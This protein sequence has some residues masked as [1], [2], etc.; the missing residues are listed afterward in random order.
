MGP[1][2][3]HEACQAGQTV[4]IR[5]AG[6]TV[7]DPLAAVIAYLREHPGT[8]ERYD[9]IAGTSDEVTAGLT[10]LRHFVTGAS[11]LTGPINDFFG[12]VLVMTDDPAVKANRLGLLASVYGL[13]ERY[14]DWDNCPSQLFPDDVGAIRGRLGDGRSAPA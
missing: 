1:L 14:L 3:E 8:V 5:V 2:D 4:P 6:R 10:E 9:F 7:G 11:A 12:Q 13:A